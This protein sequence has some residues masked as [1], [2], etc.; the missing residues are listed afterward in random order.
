MVAA[1]GGKNWEMEKSSWLTSA[2][3]P[4][5]EALRRSTSYDFAQRLDG[6]SAV[7]RK[8]FAYVLPA[9]RGRRYQTERI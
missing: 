6:G 2:W 7:R 8:Q 4:G 3:Q 1:A 5:R 9:A